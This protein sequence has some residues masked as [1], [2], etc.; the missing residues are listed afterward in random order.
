MPQSPSY[1]NTNYRVSCSAVF[2]LA[3]RPKTLPASLSPVILG[4]AMVPAQSLQWL[5]VLCALG[6]ALFLQIAVNLAN[7]FFDARH[8][9]DTDKRLGPKRVTQS[10][11]MS[12]K[13]VISGIVI[14]VLL[15]VICGLILAL[16]SSWVLLGVGALCIVATLAY[17][18]GPYP[19]ASHGL[20]EFTVLVFFGW[21]AVAGSY[22]VHTLQ[23]NWQVFLVATS[24]GLI[25]SAV[26]LVNNLRDIATDKAAGKNTLAVNIGERNSRALYTALILVAALFHVIAFSLPGGDHGFSL[27]WLPIILCSPYA[28]YC[29]HRLKYCTGAQLNSLLALTALLGLC[30]AMVTG[31]SYQ[32]VV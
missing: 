6:C 32:L 29:R 13:V 19:L 2:L 24:L 21:V 27:V 28:V 30:Y 4:S 1:Q 10:G 12:P 9:I 26:M 11:L 31:L 14:F 7:D 25:L 5:L 3:I 8:G 17:S 16:N 23:V 22:Y 20:G 15:A 18:G